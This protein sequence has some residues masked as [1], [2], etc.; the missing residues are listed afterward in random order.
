MKH[1]ST[2]EREA[3]REMIIKETLY[4]A[5]IEENKEADVSPQ[6]VVPE[7]DIGPPSDVDSLN[8]IFDSPQRHRDSAREGTPS[9]SSESRKQLL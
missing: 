5:M 1:L 3:S 6:S 8:D 2:R 4:L 7:N 9:E